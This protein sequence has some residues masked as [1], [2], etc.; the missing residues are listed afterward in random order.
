MADSALSTINDNFYLR[1]YGF[2]KPEIN[3]VVSSDLG[4][5]VV[6][7]CHREKQLIQSLE[8]LNACDKPNCSVEIIVVINASENSAQAVLQKNEQTYREALAWSKNTN[9]ERLKFHFLVHNNLPKKHAGVGLARKI[10]MEIGRAH[11]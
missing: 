7:P 3:E 10:G 8:S 4:I 2:N 5:V 11:V 6:I 9:N 1:K